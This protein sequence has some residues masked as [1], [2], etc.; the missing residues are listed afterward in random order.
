MHEIILR[1][2]KEKSLKRYHPWVFSGAIYSQD[3]PEDGTKVKVLDADGKIVGIGYYTNGSIAIRMLTFEEK[4]IN[5]SFWNQKISMALE[6]RQ[7]WNVNTKETNAFR[8]IHGEGDGIPGLVVDVYHKVIVIQ[9]HNPG[10][11]KFKQALE[12]AIYASFAK[13]EFQIV[14]KGVGQWASDRG[15]KIR[16]LEPIIQKVVELGIK[17]KVNISHGQ[18]TGFFLDQ[19]PNRQLI[20]Q[21][22]QGKS[23]CNLFCYTGGF[24]LYAK[25]GGAT[26]VDS[27]DISEPALDLAKENA[28]LNN[29]EDGHNF[30][31][32]DIMKELSNPDFPSYDLM[33]VDPPAFAKSVRKKHAAV[34]A[35]QRLNVSALKKVKPG[36]LM[37]TFSCSQVV[38]PELFENTIRSAGIISGRKITVLKKLSQGMD[39]PVNIFH[40]EGRYL[41]GLM[42]AIE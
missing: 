38:D 30:M 20:E 36:G 7:H 16:P 25:R 6:K 15:L 9:Y 4:E 29:Q 14:E 19:R 13:D 37:F 23:V 10:I 33:I 3:L 11:Y 1:K 32:A 31:A 28:K 27:L 34:K 18:K 40:P 42:L 41:K 22:S 2:G 39:H 17:F 5:E 35:Y 12:K 26:R 24:S 21:F 8:L